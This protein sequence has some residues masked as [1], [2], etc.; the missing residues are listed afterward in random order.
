M[1]AK[2]SVKGQAFLVV[3]MTLANALTSFVGG[4]CM[5]TFGVTFSLW[6]STVIT[7]AGVVVCICGLFRINAKK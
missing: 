4:G 7:L 3:A 1:P 6:F 5:Y 2:D